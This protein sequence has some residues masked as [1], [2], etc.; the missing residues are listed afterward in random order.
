[1]SR[2]KTKYIEDNAVNDVKLRLRNNQA[3]R[4][5][6]AGNTADIDILKVSNADILMILR[7][8][9]MD[10]HKITNLADPTGAQ[11]AATKNYVDAVISGLSDPKDSARVATV[12]ALPACTYAN[13]PS[14]G[15]GATLTANANGALPSIDGIGLSLNQRILVKNQAA[16][17]QNGLYVVTQLGDAGNPW[18]LTRATDADQGSAHVGEDSPRLVSQGMLVPIAE[19][20]VNGSLGFILTTVDP[21]SVGV[22]ALNFTQFG[23]VIQAGL[24]LT[25]TGQ[26]LAVDQG[27]GLG[28]SDNQLVVQVDD[29]LV[30]G[31]TKILADEVVGRRRYEQS[32]TLS[33]GDITNGYVDLT[34][35]ASRDSIGFFP[36]FGIKQRETVDFTVSYQGG[37]GGKTRITWT[38]DFASIV[39]AGDVIDINYESLDY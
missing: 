27:A 11:D 14:N 23:E 6:N 30:D 18:I 13:G 3:M 12:A 22:T 38:G 29:D 37:T 24:G 21:I 8:M 36:R 20:T 32:F 16:G 5:R 17:L 26:T 4:A 1:M 39:E 10:S 31:T 2:I 34:K 25:K 28:F 9:S 33:A 7:E 19:G 15:I 35:V